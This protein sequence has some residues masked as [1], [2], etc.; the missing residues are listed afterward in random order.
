MKSASDLLLHPLQLCMV[1]VLLIN[2]HYFKVEHPGWLSGKL[3]DV[4]FMVVCPIWTF[5]VL[6]SLLALLTSNPAGHRWLLLM[7]IIITGLFFTSMELTATGDALYR[8]ALGYL[9]WPFRGALSIAAGDVW[10]VP[11]PVLA[12]PDPTDLLCL[13]LLYVPWFMTRQGGV[14]TLNG[15]TAQSKRSPRSCRGGWTA[16]GTATR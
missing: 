16:G 5:V 9:Q 10:P 13:P 7:C 11:R 15:E 6:S 12:T 8:H 4:A 2:D 14:A 3:S 1:G